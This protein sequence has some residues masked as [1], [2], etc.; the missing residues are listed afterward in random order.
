MPDSPSL[1]LGEQL[2][3]CRHELRQPIQEMARRTGLSVLAYRE[4]EQDAPEIP[5]TWWARLLMGV[6]VLQPVFVDWEMPI[7]LHHAAG[8]LRA[9]LRRIGCLETERKAVK[10]ARIRLELAWWDQ[11]V[12][13][14]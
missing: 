13:S 1:T 14:A 2:M 7:H 11:T 6:P 8:S 9:T 5:E 3:I 12:T 10:L 4:M